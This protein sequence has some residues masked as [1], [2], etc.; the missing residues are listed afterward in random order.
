MFVSGT[1]DHM[2]GVAHE[3]I[4]AV[5]ISTGLPTAFT[6]TVSAGNAP[7]ALAATPARLY[8]GGNF[9]TVNGSPQN[10]PAALDTGTGA[11]Q[12]WDP[13][14]DGAAIDG[15]VQDIAI[16]L[17]T[18]YVAGDFQ[19]LTGKARKYLAAFD[20]DGALVESWD[21][22][23]NAAVSTIT[24]KDSTVY[25][26]GSN[27]LVTFGSELYAGVAAFKGNVLT[28]WNAAVS[29]GAVFR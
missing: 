21:P 16:L 13:N 24:A 5:S 19:S 4:A 10:R 28:S 23:P 9:T 18:V 15:A 1:F 29:G 14:K 2:G 11:R 27:A 3:Q 7:T 8:I 17:D 12:S 6:A 26:G 22:R 20:K 25:V